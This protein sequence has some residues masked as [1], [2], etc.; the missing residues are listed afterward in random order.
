MACEEGWSYI[1]EW[2][3]TPLSEVLNA[4]AGLSTQA[5]YVAYFSPSTKTWWESIDMA[6]ALHP[7]THRHRGA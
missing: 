1:A 7:Q 3:G 6:D 4:I 5:R 2:I